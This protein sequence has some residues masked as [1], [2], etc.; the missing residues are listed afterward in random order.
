MD[1][2]IHLSQKIKVKKWWQL[3]TNPEMGPFLYTLCYD[4]KLVLNSEFRT[5]GTIAERTNSIL[6]SARR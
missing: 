3:L 5:N 1:A 4:L 2:S 6:K